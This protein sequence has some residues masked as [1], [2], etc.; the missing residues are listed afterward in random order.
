M[1]SRIDE[2]LNVGVEFCGFAH[3]HPLGLSHPS[4]HDAWYS[5]RILEAFEGLDHLWIPIVMTR[6]DTGRF[7]LLPFVAARGRSGQID[8]IVRPARL[9]ILPDDPDTAGPSCGFSEHTEVL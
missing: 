2:W 1:N 7:R 8:S 6:P 3:S 9:C 5:G 4:R